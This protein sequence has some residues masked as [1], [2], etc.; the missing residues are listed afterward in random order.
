[1]PDEST[2]SA[3]KQNA[4]VRRVKV[5]ADR[6]G[7]RLDNYLATLLKGVP[8]SA[9][10]RMIRTGQVRIN[11]SRAQAASRLEEGDELRIPPARTRPDEPHTVAEDVRLQLRQAILFDSRDLLVLDKP[12]GM[13]VH[14]GSGLSW[15]V[16]DALRQ[17]RPGE[18]LELA[19]R[20][21]RETSGCLVLARSGR[22]LG[23][24]SAQFRDGTVRK[25]YL[26]LMDGLLPEAVVDV[27]A[28]L[29][30]LAGESRGP[31]A[32]Q[33]SGKASLTRFRLLQPFRDCCYVEAEL[34]TGR[35]HQIRAHARHIGLPLA[36]DRKYAERAAL[37]KWKARGLKRVFLHAHR[38]GL[39]GPAGEELEFTAPLPDDLREVLD[40]LESL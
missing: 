6:S 10:Y 13:A 2:D 28:P 33:D 8:R 7:Q 36:G 32:V 9:I 40:R 4:G 17:D 31:V 25:R 19:H 23:Q 34:F 37:K 22:A 38:L 35:T 16:I 18:Y 29:A 15:G 30:R 39:T 12:A 26:C 14:A 5:D 3:G 24:L 1:M 21:D 11:G 20:L 27:D